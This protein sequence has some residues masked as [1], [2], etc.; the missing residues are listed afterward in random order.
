MPVIDW[1]RTDLEWELPNGARALRFDQTRFAAFDLHILERPGA[2]AE[3]AEE[4]RVA[5]RRAYEA[6]SQEDVDYLIMVIASALPG[7]T[8]EPLTLPAFR[9]KLVAYHGIDAAVLRRHLV[10]FLTEVTPVAEELGVTLT[11]H[12]DDPPRPL[13]VP[14]FEISGTRFL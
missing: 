9:D 12:P 2:E 13:V 4:T 11:L 8:T 14:Q 7:S 6:M 3:Y 5:A 10:E 1:C